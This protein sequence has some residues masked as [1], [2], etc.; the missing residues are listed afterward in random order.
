[1]TASYEDKNRLAFKFAAGGVSFAH[2]FYAFPG[3]W[4]GAR[5]ALYARSQTENSKG[6]G[7]FKYFKVSIK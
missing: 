6:F 3:I 1:M 7:T 2:K 5:L 4:T